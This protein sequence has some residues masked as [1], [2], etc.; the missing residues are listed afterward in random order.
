LA[1]SGGSAQATGRPNNTGGVAQLA[2]LMADVP[3]DRPIIVVGDIDAKSTGEW[4]GLKG[5]QDT[6]AGLSQQLGRPVA[7]ALP[8]DNAKDVRLWFKGRKPDLTRA[9]VLRDLGGELLAGLKGRQIGAGND[10][11]PVSAPGGVKTGTETGNRRVFAPIV[12]SQLKKD[13]RLTRYLWDGYIAVGETVLLSA[14]WKAGK[15]TLCSR[16]LRQMGLREPNFCGLAVESCKVVYVTEEAEGTWVDRRDKLGLGDHLRFVIRPFIC[17]PAVADWHGFLAD[18]KRM[19]QQDPADLIVLDP[20]DKLWPVKDENNAAEVTAAL[21]PLHQLEP[22]PAIL[23]IHHL[24][25]NDGGEGTGTRGSGALMAFVDRIHELRRYDA[26]A[27]AD[28]RRV[29]TSYGRDDDANRE[30]VV[31]LNK[32]GL[33]YAA[34]GDRD[35]AG[36]AEFV[37]TI[38]RLLP[39]KSP[40]WTFEEIMEG[41]DG[42]RTPRRKKLL[43]ELKRGAEAEPPDWAREGG[44]K[45]GSPYTY[46]IDPDANKWRCKVTPN[47]EDGEEF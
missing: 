2:V 38:R 9:D 15:T 1:L 37:G 8:P 47:E 24:R 18:L 14:L 26:S 19:Q 39:R 45:K 35:K 5:A 31:E 34:H 10:S 7:W 42:E 44:G 41:W 11:V 23:L 16:L 25:K 4:P 32:D 29:I 36:H 20:I 27:Q 40:G 30:M 28:R 46:W 12:C 6:A 17:K 21:M 33:D 3:K 43:D 13:N 22:H